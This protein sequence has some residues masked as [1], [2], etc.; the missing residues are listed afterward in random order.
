[1]TRVNPA[2]YGPSDDGSKLY[3]TRRDP[4][5]GAGPAASQLYGGA[6]GRRLRIA[7]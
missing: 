3:E 4:S 7:L 5:I 6:C 1:M 2:I